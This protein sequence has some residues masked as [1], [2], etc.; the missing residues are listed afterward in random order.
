M[1]I[2]RCV[3][4]VEKKEGCTVKYFK[5]RT[6]FLVSFSGLVLLLAFFNFNCIIR[7]ESI[8]NVGN[9]NNITDTANVTILSQAV[10][11]LAS[12]NIGLEENIGYSNTRTLGTDTTAANPANWITT[13]SEDNCNYI[14]I[15]DSL[16]EDGECVFSSTD[17]TVGVCLIRFIVETGVIVD[18]T[19]IVSKTAYDDFS[20]TAEA[21]NKDIRNIFIHEIGHCLGLQHWG[22][23]EDPEPAEVNSGDYETHIMYPYTGLTIYEPHVQE[24]AAIQN[25]YNSTGLSSCNKNDFSAECVDP[26]SLSNASD[27]GDTTIA[28]G[29]YE[30]YLPCYYTPNKDDTNAITN[31]IRQST[32]PIFYISAYIGNALVTADEVFPPGPPITGTVREVMFK[33]KKDGSEEIKYLDSQK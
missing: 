19:L 18:S 15:P 9:T 2:C 30:S 11:A 20:G 14:G 8:T 28:Y 10:T 6:P 29:T 5:Y 17:P 22:D 13:A 12:W 16:K 25:V 24:L 4:C 27:C 32:F 31:R 23:P 3:V 7:S 33:I 21:K 1:S 26:N